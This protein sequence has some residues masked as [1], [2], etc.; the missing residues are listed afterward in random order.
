MDDLLNHTNDSDRFT[1]N[2]I[3]QQNKNNISEIVIGAEKLHCHLVY[4]E[5]S[6]KKNQLTE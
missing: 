2:N 3:I 6:K 5:N 1:D 4:P